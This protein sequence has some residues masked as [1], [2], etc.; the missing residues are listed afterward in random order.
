M[1][2][3]SLTIMAGRDAEIAVLYRHW[4]G[5]IEGHGRELAEFLAG[6]RVAN[7]YGRPDVKL[8]NGMD[9]L[10]AQIVARFKAG[11]GDFYL[12][13]AGTRRVGEDFRYH[14][15]GGP[16][17]PCIRAEKMLYAGDSETGEAVTVLF[18]GPASEMLAW[19]NATWPAAG[20]Q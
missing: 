14:V 17:E 18:D 7:G 15:Y 11:T 5:Y 12:Q 9:C 19:I 4:D 13:P 1:G 8:A 10:A 6:F 2:T 20:G 16:S 3:R